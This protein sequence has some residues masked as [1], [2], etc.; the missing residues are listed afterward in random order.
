MST[1]KR[2]ILLFLGGLFIILGVL[3]LFLPFLQ[4]ILFLVIGTILL[5]RASPWVHRRVRALRRR[6]PKLDH[7]IRESETRAERLWSRI[8]GNRA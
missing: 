2:W 7:L 8:A 5:S 4:G 3:G 6:H 1:A